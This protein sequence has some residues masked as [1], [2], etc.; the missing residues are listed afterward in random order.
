MAVKGAS[1]TAIMFS[2]YMH[3]MV[4]YGRAFPLSAPA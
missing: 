2:P 3:R 1:M 4:E